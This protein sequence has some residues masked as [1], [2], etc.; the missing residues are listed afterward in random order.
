WRHAVCLADLSLH[1]TL[2]RAARIASALLLLTL[3]G[4]A[5]GGDDTDDEQEAETESAFTE[6]GMTQRCSGSEKF[7]AAN[8]RQIDVPG[9]VDPDFVFLLCVDRTKDRKYVRA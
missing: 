6:K 8:E 7:V 5:A 9:G 4:C 1:M 2:I 3:P